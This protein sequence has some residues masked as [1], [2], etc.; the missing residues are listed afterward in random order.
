MVRVV[1]FQVLRVRRV[2]LELALTRHFAREAS[3]LHGHG[4]TQG[5][6]LSQ[7]NLLLVDRG[8]VCGGGKIGEEAA[9]GELDNGELALEIAAAEDGAWSDWN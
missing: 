4:H 2:S 6:S 7:F 5:V 3:L 1:S 9:I 8:G